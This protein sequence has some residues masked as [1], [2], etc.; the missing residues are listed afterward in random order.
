MYASTLTQEKTGVG[1]KSW[2]VG[3]FCRL[4]PGRRGRFSQSLTS[5][6]DK[7]ELN[8]WRRPLTGQCQFT[9]TR[10]HNKGL[11]LSAPLSFV[12][13]VIILVLRNVCH[14]GLKKCRQ[15]SKALTL[16]SGTA[17]KGCA[18]KFKYS[19]DWHPENLSL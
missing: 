2:H 8:S 10:I 1:R 9:Q 7:H 4:S 3:H 14:R 13:S 16:M 11:G 18:K 15:A 12:L 5:N 17:A 19:E 6:G